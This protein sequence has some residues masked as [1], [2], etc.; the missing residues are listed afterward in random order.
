MCC[1][2]I[3]IL[4]HV[5]VAGNCS[6]KTVVSVPSHRH[7]ASPHVAT[8]TGSQSPFFSFSVLLKIT[9]DRIVKIITCS[10]G[11]YTCSGR[12]LLKLR[13]NLCDHPNLAG[14]RIGLTD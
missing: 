14:V 12:Q 8:G 11:L 1:L 6:E 9:L 4:V 13:V 5:P 10:I 3:C 7:E 2:I